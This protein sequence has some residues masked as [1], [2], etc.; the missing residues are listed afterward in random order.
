MTKTTDG[1]NFTMQVRTEP[2]PTGVG[3]TVF[4]AVVVWDREAGDNKV[5]VE[6][7]GE[8]GRLSAS[9]WQ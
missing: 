1:T 5:Q 6:V 3:A 7:F 2:M 8:S 4:T 9:D